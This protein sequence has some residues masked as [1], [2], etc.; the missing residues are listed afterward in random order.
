MR[1]SDWSSDVCSSDL[2]Q[3]RDLGRGV[4][5][6][7]RRSLRLA[8]HG[9][10]RAVLVLKTQ[11]VE[12]PDGAQDA[13]RGCSVEL[14]QCL[15]PSVCGHAFQIDERGTAERSEEHTSELQS[16]MRIS[17]AVFC[18]TKKKIKNVS[19][20]LLSQMTKSYDNSSRYKQKQL[21]N[22]NP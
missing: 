19:I 17:Y 21:E 9:V 7:E 3:H 2:D 12:Q 18:L 8:L 5:V 11:L 4:E 6:E 20:Q 22:K 14:H 10:D 15:A 13:G 16:L 1:I